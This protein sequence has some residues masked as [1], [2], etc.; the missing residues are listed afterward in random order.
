SLS[1]GPME[2]A[3]ASSQF[4]TPG[5]HEVQPDFSVSVEEEEEAPSLNSTKER[6]E[7]RGS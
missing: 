7:A 4:Y 3:C 2:H 1:E 6:F 5:F